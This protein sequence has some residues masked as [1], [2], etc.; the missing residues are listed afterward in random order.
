MRAI[1]DDDGNLANGTPHSCN[2]FAAFNRHGLACAA[3]LAAN[4]CFAACTPPA[5][6]GLTLT[7]S[8]NRVTL[9]LSGTGVFD[10]YRNETGCNAGFTKIANDVAATSYADT[11]VANGVTYY[12]LAVAQPSGNEPC[13]SPPSV[14]RSTS[15]TPDQPPTARFTF[16]CTGRICSFDGS[17]STDDVGISSYAWNFGDGGTGTGV[18]PSHTYAANGT[19]TVTLTVTDTASQTNQASHA[20]SVLDIPPTASFYVGCIDRTCTADSEASGDDYGIV[21]YTWTWGDGTTTTGGSPVSAPSHTYTA[22]GTYTITLTVRDI[23]GQ[24]S[25][26][27]R[28]ASASRG[29]SPAFTFSCVGR[30]CD[31]DGSGSTS[32]VAITGYHWDWGDESVTDATV[33]TAHHVFLYDGT[34]TVHLVVTDAAGK[35]ADISHPVTVVDYPPTASFYAGCINLT[36]TA[37]SEASGDDYGI[38]NYT[39]T[40]GDGATTTGGSPVSAPSHTYAAAGTYTITLTVRD[41]AGQTSTTSHPV[42]VS[43]GPTAAFTFH[44]TGL[45]CSFDAS[46]STSNVAITNYHWDWSD[47]SVTDTASA[48]AQHVY[49]YSSS[50]G[51]TLTITDANG[52]TAQVTHT[53]T[54]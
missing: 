30:I 29:P 4:T 17:T 48:T 40:W 53:V 50:F 25:T 2:L 23:A 11:A 42:T 9:N 7:P 28:T 46:G 47:E 8:D 14:C 54:P 1:D 3:D 32:D 34:F 33:P 13:A 52:A 26:T 31:F 16:T 19:F 38:V 22:Y 39:W 44:C 18:T 6:P 41:I 49:A 51:V 5:A 20:V 35:T 27:T 15:P 24:T 10:L 43:R 37:D 12:Y 36:C 45:T 21:N